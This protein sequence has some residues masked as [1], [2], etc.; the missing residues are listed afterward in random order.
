M[1]LKNDIPSWIPL[2]GLTDCEIILIVIFLRPLPLSNILAITEIRRTNWRFTG[3][4]HKWTMYTCFRDS[5]SRFA[6]QICINFIE[7]ILVFIFER[8]NVFI[9]II[10][11]ILI[12]I[13]VINDD[14]FLRRV[15][16]KKTIMSHH[17]NK[18]IMFF[19]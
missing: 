6:F 8:F 15:P 1:F 5:C 3:T 18:S 19:V 16:F 2:R 10:S 13:V 11:V 9:L 7:W 14:L 4:T 17:T 12:S